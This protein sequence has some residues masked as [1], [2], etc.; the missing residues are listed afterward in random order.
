MFQFVFNIIRLLLAIL[1][2]F[3]FLA[4]G[5][6]IWAEIAP[7]RTSFGANGTRRGTR[8]ILQKENQQEGKPIVG[9]T[10]EPRARRFKSMIPLRRVILSPPMQD[11]SAEPWT[12][13]EKRKYGRLDS[14]GHCA[15]CFRG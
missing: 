1:R 14:H 13:R 12:A 3:L 8:Q 5:Q 2:V 11:K 4:S 7:E 9:E 6:S 10:I 15:R